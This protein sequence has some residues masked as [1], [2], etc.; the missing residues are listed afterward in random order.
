MK[1]FN[2]CCFFLATAKLASAIPM[3]QLPADLDYGAHELVAYG[4]DEGELRSL[5]TA[6]PL[7]AG[8][9]YRRF[10]NIIMRIGTS[11]AI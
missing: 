2:Q 5:I 4:S 11:S 10:G 3:S 6:N 7:K 1:I 8:I 9:N